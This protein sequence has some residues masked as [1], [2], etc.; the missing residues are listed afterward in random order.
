MLYIVGTP[1]GNLKDITLRALE[2]LKSADVIAC[3]D[4]RRTLTLLN[5]YEIKKP[6]ISY[7]K[8]NEKECGEKLVARLKSGE[9]VALVS[10]AGMPL[11]SDPGE[12]LVRR[13]IDEGLDFTVIPGPTAFV[14][15]LALS[16]LDTSRFCFFG[17]LPERKS[18]RE[19]LLAEIKDYT[20]TLAFYCAP[21]DVKNTVSQLY[22]A[23]G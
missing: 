23:L 3:E 4:T 5:A 18:E 20:A 9:N 13:L 14:S 15:A 10:D 19:K 12:T 11:V 1:I 8:F 22:A 16:G 17:F 6:L 2:T 7:H 21:H